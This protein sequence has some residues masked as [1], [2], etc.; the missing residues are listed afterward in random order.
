ML[1]VVIRFIH[2]FMVIC[3]LYFALISRNRNLILV[4]C[5]LIPFIV[6][7]WLTNNNTCCLTELEKY[8]RGICSEETFFGKLINPVYQV[9][10]KNMYMGT[11]IVWIIGVFRLR[12]CE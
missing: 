12:I 10:N 1:S 3:I 5:I 6:A 2:L 9:S 4:A 11:V 8:C 7:H